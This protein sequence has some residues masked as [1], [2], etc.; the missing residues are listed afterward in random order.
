MV[1]SVKVRM[2]LDMPFG[3]QS[4]VGVNFLAGSFYQFSSA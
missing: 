3:G 2:D 4:I 1:A